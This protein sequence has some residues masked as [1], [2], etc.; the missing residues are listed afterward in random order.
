MITVLVLLAVLDLGGSSASPGL[1]DSLTRA[2]RVRLAEAN[3][4]RRAVANQVWAG[5]AVPFAVLLVTDS[6]EFLIWHPRPSAEFVSVGRDS[7]LETEVF[8]RSRQFAPNL[9]ATFPAVGGVPTIVVGRPEATGRSSTGWVV[10]LLHEHFHQMQ[11]SRPGYYEG[12]NGLGLSRGDQTGMWM[13]NF[14]FPYDSARVEGAYRAVA[15]TLAALLAGSTNVGVGSGR[16]SLAAQWNRLHSV[17]GADDLKYLEF[18]LWQEGVARYIEILV[19]EAAART[20]RPSAEFTQLPDYRTYSEVATRT[21]AQM[22]AELREPKLGEIKRVSFYSL[23]A[24]LALA[25]D[26]LEADWRSRYFLDPF[27]LRPPFPSG[28]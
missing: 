12:V 19:A 11:Y 18:Q 20:H 7:L 13:L 3:R 21:R 8:V 15:G 2:D 22:M 14:P 24:G 16:D 4:L 5:W 17:L 25:L 26:R 23:G 10:T 6:S 28:R 1:P 27:V 9:L